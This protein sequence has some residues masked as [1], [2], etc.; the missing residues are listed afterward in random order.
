M[1]VVSFQRIF[2]LTSIGFNAKFCITRYERL[3]MKTDLA[4]EAEVM[5]FHSGLTLVLGLYIVFS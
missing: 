5:G 1:H 4:S 3:A 2:S